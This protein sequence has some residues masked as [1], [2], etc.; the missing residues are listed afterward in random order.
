MA[1]HIEDQA[2]E[3]LVEAIV[4]LTGETVTEV[5]R[6]ALAERR[7]R[8]APISSVPSARRR[9]QLFLEEEVWPQIP[10]QQLG[11][12]LTEDEETAIL[13]YDEMG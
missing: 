5:V 8:L 11:M 3:E 12:P 4:Q 7:Q 10:A 6:Q 13:G 1:L 9:L 2:V